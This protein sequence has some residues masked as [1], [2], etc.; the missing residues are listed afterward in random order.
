MFSNSSSYALHALQSVLLELRSL[1]HG[2]VEHVF[3]R[4]DANSS[5][6]KIA[7]LLDPHNICDLSMC[8]TI[9]CCPRY[10][11]AGRTLTITIALSADFPCTARPELEVAIATLSMHASI[12]IALVSGAVS[13]ELLMTYSPAADRRSVSATASVP[14]DVTRDSVIRISSVTVAGKPILADPVLPVHTCFMRNVGPAS[15]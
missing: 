2:I 13:Q 1:P 15:S 3:M 5:S 9:C 7:S 6:S 4:L 14:K 10:A 8:R 12:D 11:H